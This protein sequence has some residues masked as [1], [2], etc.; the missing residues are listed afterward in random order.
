MTRSTEVK[1]EENFPIT[2]WGYT[3]GK[4]LDNTECDILVDTGTSK[5]YMSKSYSWG[6]KVCI[7]YPNLLPPQQESKLEMDNM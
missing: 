6:V 2:V 3:K 7:P 4:L 1:A 5:S